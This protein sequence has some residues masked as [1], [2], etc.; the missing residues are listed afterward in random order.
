MREEYL[1]NFLL[2]FLSA[3]NL[4]N[5][6]TTKKN[7]TI[8]ELKI[9]ALAWISDTAKRPARVIR[10]AINLKILYLEFIRKYIAKGIL[11]AIE[12]AV[13]FLFPAKPLICITLS[14]S[15]GYII[16]RS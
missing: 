15:F 7:K 12:A 13:I 14:P 1:I 2:N 10:K 8:I 16:D 11:K 6:K 3:K 9:A 5:K 4:Y